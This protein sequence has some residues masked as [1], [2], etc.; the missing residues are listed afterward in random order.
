M[1][2]GM[3]YDG[4]NW[5]S[6]AIDQH[7]KLGEVYSKLKWIRSMAINCDLMDED[8]DPRMR[9]MLGRRL[10][11][12]ESRRAHLPTTQKSNGNINVRRL[13]LSTV[14]CLTHACVPFTHL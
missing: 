9:T 3:V 10:V 1:T 14:C 4:S 2:Q 8:E 11:E 6:E 13:T 5:M 12:A 7:K